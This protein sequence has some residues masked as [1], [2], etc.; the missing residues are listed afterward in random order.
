MVIFN[1][2]GLPNDYLPLEGCKETMLRVSPDVVTTWQDAVT[3]YET[4]TAANLWRSSGLVGSYM[5]CH[6]MGLGHG[7]RSQVA[8]YDGHAVTMN[9]PAWWRLIHSNRPWRKR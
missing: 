4:G 3:W 6:G 2:S 8:F 7:A 1:T 5:T 9:L